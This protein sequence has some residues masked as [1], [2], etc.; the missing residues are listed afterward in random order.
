MFEKE[1]AL[2][3]VIIT[4]RTVDYQLVCSLLCFLFPARQFSLIAFL[5]HPFVL[6]FAKIRVLAK[7]VFID[8]CH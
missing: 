3:K 6:F 5:S 2:A 8:Y 1:T 7:D 4:V